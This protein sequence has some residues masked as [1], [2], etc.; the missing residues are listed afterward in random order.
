MPDFDVAIIGAGAS[1]LCAAAELCRQGRTVVLL[2]ARERIGGRIY[3]QRLP[4]LPY[5]LELGAEFIH[6]GAPLTTALLRAAGMAAVDTTGVRVT[7]ADGSGRAREAAFTGAR[8]L[9]RQAA[10]LPQDLSVEQFL[11]RH[12]AGPGLE[13]ARSTVLMMVEGFDA[14]DPQRAS[15]QAIA[16]E[17]DGASMAGQSRPLGGYQALMSY[18]AGALEPARARLLLA[19]RAE[20]IEWG[21]GAVRIQAQGAAGALTLTARRAILTVPVNLL[22]PQPQAQ[23]PAHVPAAI[24]FEPA[25]PPDKRAALDGIALGPVIKVVLQFRCAFWEQLEQGRFAEAGFMHAPQA[26][27]PTLWTALPF[28]VPLLTA[29]MGGPRA[30]RQEGA[31]RTQL[32]E[33]AVASVQEVL[34]VGEAVVVDELVAGH[35]HD[36]GGD[37]YARGAYSYLTV[38]AAAA[39]QTLAQPVRATL[40]FAGEAASSEY[41]GTVEAALQSGQLAARAI[42]AA[43]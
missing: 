25:L 14:A 38:G 16:R 20:L 32:I 3:T 36:W 28:R 18:L 7:R 39:P 11:R 29:W 2:E 33:Q 12:A 34:G 26:P 35:V 17:W 10:S 21:D 24:R 42:V 40:F 6:G 30:Q 37:P 5:P 13:S 41:S 8:D 4:D 23:P 1:G 43:D 31:S 15:V 19:T 27:F 22:Q 9:L